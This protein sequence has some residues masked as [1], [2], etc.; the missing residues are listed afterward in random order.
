M[1]ERSVFVERLAS[2]RVK[3]HNQI[4]REEIAA[5]LGPVLPGAVDLHPPPCVVFDGRTRRPGLVELVEGEWAIGCGT[6]YRPGHVAHHDTPTVRDL[7]TDPT[8]GGFGEVGGLEA[9]P[10]AESEREKCTG[11]AKPAH[12]PDENNT[13]PDDAGADQRSKGR[14]QEPHGC[15]HTRAVLVRE[16]HHHGQADKHPKAAQQ[17]G[18]RGAAPR[19]AIVATPP[20][21]AAMAHDRAPT[22]APVTSMSRLTG[23]AQRTA[24]GM[25]TA[26][27]P[28]AGNFTYQIGSVTMAARRSL[29]G[30]AVRLLS[31]GQITKMASS[32]T[33]TMPLTIVARCFRVDSDPHS[34]WQGKQDLLEAP[35]R[36][37]TQLTHPSPGG[38]AA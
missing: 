10:H 21:G 22:K 26:P 27:V 16:R 18:E 38:R 8:G 11:G 34:Q 32:P 1:T 30:T 17:N 19:F 29:N 13:F 5:I 6:H 28:M 9:Y 24:S 31:P 33:A 37:K 4:R 15:E 2:Q 12:H 7:R 25:E 23:K 20:V 3:A 35:G 36:R 14:E